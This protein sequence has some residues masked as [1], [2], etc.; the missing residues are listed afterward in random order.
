M[1]NDF[2]QLKN[3]VTSKINQLQGD[4]SIF[5]KFT[6]SNEIISLNEN[7]QFWA[8]SLIK[9]VVL[10]ELF[11]Q[12]YE[13]NLD[14]TK[15][16]KIATNN[17]VK[18]SGIIH[19]LDQNNE[20]SLLDLAKLMIVLSDNV[21]TNQIIDILGRENIEQTPQSLGLKNTFF[22][23]KMRIVEVK[24]PNMTTA[25]DMAVLFE[26]LYDNKLSGSELMLEIMNETKLRDR[27]PAFIPNDVIIPH[28]IGSLEMG[29]H[30]V[31]IIYA[32]RPFIFSFLSDDQPNKMK[33]ALAIATCAKLCFD[34]AQ[35]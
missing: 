29:V 14:L 34:Y 7:V 2:E 22:R 23:N 12:V 19:L 10:V 18:G 33:T 9:V 11:R 35:Q 17:M 16:Y 24:G 25:K 26:T 3:A 21:A 5:I 8:A 1:I 31:G 30:D 27:I 15:K 4:K 6:D 20:F 13:R 28:K 32:K